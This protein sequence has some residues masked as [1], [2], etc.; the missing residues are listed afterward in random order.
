MKLKTEIKGWLAFIILGFI[1]AGVLAFYKIPYLDGLR[2]IF[3]AVYV[4]FLPG[5][6]VVRCF[7]DDLEDWIEK[8]GVAFGL[9]IAIIVLAVM[10]SNL[11]LRIPIT[12]LSN[13]LVILGAMAITVLLK[14]FV[15]KRKPSKKLKNE[16]K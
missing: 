16:N 8:F 5:W 1:G 7:F 12:A 3:G 11:V 9:S 6:V 13:F 14:E 15:K 10:F 4:L 2:I